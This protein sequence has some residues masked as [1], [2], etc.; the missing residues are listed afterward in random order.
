MSDM[1][2]MDTIYA[3]ISVEREKQKRTWGEGDTVNAPNDWISLVT[4]HLGRAVH[5]PWS[6]RTFRHQM[7][8]VAALAVA[9]IEWADSDGDQ[10]EAN[11]KR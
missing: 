2:S 3:E 1:T 10:H 6:V 11:A 5:W 8:I 4:K 9:A 7:V